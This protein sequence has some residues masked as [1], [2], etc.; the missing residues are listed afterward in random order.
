MHSFD[1]PLGRTGHYN[2]RTFTTTFDHYLPLFTADTLATRATICNMDGDAPFFDL[3]ALGGTDGFRGY[4]N[5]QFFDRSLMSLQAEYRGRFS[6]RWGWVAFAG[7]GAGAVAD[8]FSEFN[9]NEIK[10]AV[11]AGA[12]YRL[13]ENFG[14]DFS[15]DLAYGEEGAAAY[16]YLGQN[17]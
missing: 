13:S 4:P 3:C 5:G 8:G 17:S 10:P 6:P 14:L 1:E 9:F 12:R 2:Y 7:A 15:A 11:G 16:V